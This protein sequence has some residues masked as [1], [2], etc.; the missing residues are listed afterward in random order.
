MQKVSS[1]PREMEKT[2][3]TKYDMYFGFTTNHSGKNILFPFQQ[4]Y[5]IPY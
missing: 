1:T 2:V 3:K 4:V 5:N